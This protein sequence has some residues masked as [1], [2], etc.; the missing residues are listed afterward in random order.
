M[1]KIPRGAACAA[2]SML[3]FI[4]AGSAPAAA[5]EGAKDTVSVYTTREKQLVEPML[6]LFEGLSRVKL[7]ITY[8]T[9]APIEELRAA[10]AENKVDLF[11]AAELSDLA[12]A[13]GLGLTEPVENTDL[14]E[15]IPEIYR[16]PEGHWFGL[17]KRTRVVAASRERV[18]Q[19]AFTYEELADPKWKG[20]LCIRSGLHA[21]NV[22]LVASLIAHKGPEFAE[23]WVKGVKA[24]LAVKPIGGDRD[25]IAGVAAGKCDVALVQSYYVGAMRSAKDRPELQATGNAVEVIFPNAGDRGTHASISGMA[26]IKD[27]PAINN[28]TLLMDFLTSEPA[29]FVYA[30]DNHE[31]PVR[32]GTKPSGLVDSWG[33]PKLDDIPLADIA[34]LQPQAVELIRKAGFDAG[35]GS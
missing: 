31:Y 10:A 15:R 5:A 34:R 30:Q 33:K 22:T 13:K 9:D 4:A 18:K 3:A 6:R 2:S 16:D 24:N 35:P 23:S 29:Q 14:A 25:Q 7:E 11:I 32:A 8:L 1:T 19:K 12:A 27:A 21:Y 20:K 28:A 26:L 17:T